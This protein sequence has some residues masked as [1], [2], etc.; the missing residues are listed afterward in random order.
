MPEYHSDEFLCE[1]RT[2]AKAYKEL[3][4]K[5]TEYITANNLGW[6]EGNIVKYVSRWKY[7][8]GLEDLLKARDYLNQLISTIHKE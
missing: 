3:S 4:I 5:P 6:H 2:Y 1:E 8:G 7:K